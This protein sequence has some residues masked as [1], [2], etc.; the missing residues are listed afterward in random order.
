MEKCRLHSYYRSSCSWRVRLAL[1]LKQIPYEIAPVNLLKNEQNSPDFLA[2][3]PSGAVPALEIDGQTLNQSLAILEYLEEAGPECCSL[4]PSHPAERAQ[5][6]RLCL[7]I[8]ADCQP[9]QNFNVQNRIM[10]LYGRS[11]P[12]VQQ[13]WAAHFISRGLEAFERAAAPH[14]GRFSFGDQLSWADLCLVPQLYNAR[15]FGIDVEARF[16]RL[17]AIEAAFKS[18][19]PVAF[20]SAHPESQPDYQ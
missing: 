18:D 16:P 1:E 12:E 17:A 5:V 19:F 14:S 15:R 2:K 10:E 4:L 9:L 3:N 20:N 7:I 11:R 8:A 13:E 6:R